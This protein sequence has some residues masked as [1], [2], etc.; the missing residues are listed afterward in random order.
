MKMAGKG[1]ITSEKA[2]SQTLIHAD[3]VE[4]TPTFCTTMQKNNVYICSQLPVKRGG[5]C[6][7]SGCTC[8]HH[9]LRVTFGSHGSCTIVLLLEYEK[10][11]EMVA[12]VPL[13]M[14]TRSLPLPDR[15]SSCHVTNVT[16]GE[17]APL[18]RILHNFRLRMHIVYFRS[19]PLPVTWLTSLP[20][21]HAHVI[22]S[23]CSPTQLPHKCAVVRA[24]ILLWS[25]RS[26][27]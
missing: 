21:A 5:Y 4:N 22:T 8:A 26:K 16:S 10:T 2:T 15:A 1:Q 11:L 27:K 9:P 14:R 20:V 23:G 3:V 19:G 6:A 17:K 13:R 25:V 12:Q 18:R 7:T 24:H